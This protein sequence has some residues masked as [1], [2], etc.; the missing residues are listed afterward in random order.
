[1]LELITTETVIGGL[2]LLGGIAYGLY[3]LGMLPFFK[4]Q[5][6]KES[7]KVGNNPTA[8]ATCPD[9]GCKKELKES[10]GGLET[11]QRENHNQ[12]IKVSSYQETLF[13]RLD[14]FEEKI[15]RKVDE[16]LKVAHTLCGAIQKGNW[17]Q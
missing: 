17:R 3:R 2:T 13:N 8:P 16:A 11:Q 9:L 14:R 4:K 15:E 6:N 10:M 5:P 7:A 1:M 12:L